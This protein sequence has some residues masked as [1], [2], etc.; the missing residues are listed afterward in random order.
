MRSYL[1]FLH[2]AMKGKQKTSISIAV[3]KYYELFNLAA[4]FGYKNI[5]T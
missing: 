1:G 3:C 5:A 4:R 2:I